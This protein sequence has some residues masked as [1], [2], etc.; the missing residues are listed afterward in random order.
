MKIGALAIE[1]ALN[2]ALF[3]SELHWVRSRLVL[4]V[5]LS[6]Y[7]WFPAVPCFCAHCTTTRNKGRAAKQQRFVG[8]R[9]PQFTPLRSP[10]KTTVKQQLHTTHHPLP[11]FAALG[12]KGTPLFASNHTE[13]I[14]FGVINRLMS[15]HRWSFART[16][17]PLFV[18]PFNLHCRHRHYH[19]HSA[20]Y[21][22]TDILYISKVWPLPAWFQSAFNQ[23]LSSFIAPN[24]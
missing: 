3:N 18:V 1:G 15:I 6:I 9:S 23:F 7:R 21:L 12:S 14:R 24:N 17:W 20:M 2:N 16:V 22:S 19:C 11:G 4:R 13:I 8:I 10:T 5:C